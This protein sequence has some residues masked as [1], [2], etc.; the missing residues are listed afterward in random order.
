M[1]TTVQLE[2]DISAALLRL[3]QKTGMG[4]S[5]AVNHLIRRGLAEQTNTARFVQTTFPL[6]LVVDVSNVAEALER[7]EGPEYR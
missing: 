2:K 3:R 7:L 4:V 1:R 5:E 6:G